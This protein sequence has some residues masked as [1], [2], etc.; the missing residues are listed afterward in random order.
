MFLA[1]VG[2]RLVRAFELAERTDGAKGARRC[3]RGA[4]FKP[5]QQQVEIK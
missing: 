1:S 3:K 5:K 2:M 4:G